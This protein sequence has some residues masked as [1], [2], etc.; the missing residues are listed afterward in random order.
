M[1]VSN[2]AYLK[3]LMGTA[4][5]LGD[6][7]VSSDAV[8][9]IEGFENLQ[10]LFKQFP[11]P[12]LSPQ[13]EINVPL[14]LG[15]EMVQPQQ[16]KLA[17][18]GAVTCVETVAGHIRQFQEKILNQGARFNAKI[19]DGTP[20]DF[21]TVLPIFQAFIQF[22]TPDRD[23]ENRGSLLTLSGTMFYHYVGSNG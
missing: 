13:G 6:K 17:Q 20:E 19:Y 21:N 5:A 15:L 9:V 22:D 7:A 8:M 18:Q 14:P 1:T 10:L 4:L 16:V 12:Q 2:G 23:W 3:Q 11:W